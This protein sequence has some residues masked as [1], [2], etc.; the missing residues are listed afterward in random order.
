MCGVVGETPSCP[1]PFRGRDPAAPT[2][3]ELKD[4]VASLVPPPERGRSGGGLFQV[5]DCGLT[6]VQRCRPE[7]RVEE[8]V[9]EL[10]FLG[11]GGLD[12][13][14]GAVAAAVAVLVADDGGAAEAHD[15]ATL[16]DLHMP[17]HVGRYVQLVYRPLITVH[18]AL[19]SF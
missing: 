14:F 15:L 17:K 7:C 13:F 5:R 11:R 1:P 12:E 6:L 19:L 16:D 8:F 10:A 18:A 4:S 3:P 2:Y 9:D